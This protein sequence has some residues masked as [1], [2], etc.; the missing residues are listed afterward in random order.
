[1][2]LK[3]IDPVLQTSIETHSRLDSLMEP[4]AYKPP[5]PHW[6]C[7]CRP[8]PRSIRPFTR[9]QNINSNYDQNYYNYS[10]NYNTAITA[11]AAS[12]ATT[13][14]TTNI[15]ATTA[16]TTLTTHSKLADFV[17]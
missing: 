4:L 15:T 1:M 8:P 13:V 14:T 2:I 16:A 10:N 5:L 9:P 7:I 3:Q 12:T 11:A 6:P 17:K